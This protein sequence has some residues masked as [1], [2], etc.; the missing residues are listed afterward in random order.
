MEEGLDGLAFRRCSW[1]PIRDF[2]KRGTA[3]LY[4]VFRK[5]RKEPI[6]NIGTWQARIN[7]GAVQTAF[8][9]R[10]AMDRSMAGGEIVNNQTNPPVA[11]P[12]GTVFGCYGCTATPKG[13]WTWQRT[14]VPGSSAWVN[15]TAGRE[16]TPAQDGS[17]TDGRWVV[18]D[19]VRAGKPTFSVYHRCFLDH[20]LGC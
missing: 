1:L 13:H 17:R 3:S 5:L 4:T 11:P 16:I 7:G 20:R 12:D 6:D 18:V 2:V 15:V 14:S 19:T 9:N 8:L 10:D